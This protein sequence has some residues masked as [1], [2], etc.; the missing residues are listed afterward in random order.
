[1]MRGTE[2]TEKGYLFDIV[3]DEDALAHDEVPICPPPD[4]EDRGESNG[5]TPT[6]AASTPESGFFDEELGEFL[7]VPRV[8]PRKLGKPRAFSL[9]SVVRKLHPYARLL[10]VWAFPIWG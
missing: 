10:I 9:S 1:M 3:E 7:P 2:P 4:N 6:S 5:Y 8:W